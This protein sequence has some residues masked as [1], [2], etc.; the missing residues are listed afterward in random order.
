MAVGSCGLQ[1]EP[2]GGWTWQRMGGST[3]PVCAD[4]ELE[5]GVKT[6]PSQPPDSCSGRS[7]RKDE[8]NLGPI[9]PLPGAELEPDCR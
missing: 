3:V 6:L 4:V 9:K 2:L 5:K 8:Q 7:R 1:K